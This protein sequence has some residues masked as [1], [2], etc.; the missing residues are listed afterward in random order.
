MTHCLHCFIG[1]TESDLTVSAKRAVVALYRGSWGMDAVVTLKRGQVEICFA[2]LL[3]RHHPGSHHSP[4]ERRCSPGLQY[5]FWRMSHDAQT[6]FI[7]SARRDAD[8]E[9]LV[10]PHG[11][12]IWDI[13]HLCAAWHH[14]TDSH[15]HMQSKTQTAEDSD[16]ALTWTGLRPSAPV[17]VTREA[18]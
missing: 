18:T 3:L 4:V 10:G 14:T 17:F 8:E 1:C 7:S 2:E 12:G 11:R 15:V 9:L 13:L 16:A 5:H 6:P